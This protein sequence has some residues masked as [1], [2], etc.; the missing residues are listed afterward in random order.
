MW[1]Q[2]LIKE[3]FNRILHDVAMNYDDKLLKIMDIQ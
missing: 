3:D 1:I 2:Y